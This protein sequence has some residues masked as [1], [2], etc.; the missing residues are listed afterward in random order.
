[1]NL[2]GISDMDILEASTNERTFQRG[3]MYYYN[4]RV[5]GL[6]FNSSTMEY[7]AK[8]LGSEVY[9]VRITADEDGEIDSFY[10][11]CPAFKTYF[12]LCK[13]IVAFLFILRDYY[14]DRHS[15]ISNNNKSIEVIFEYISQ[16]HQS[17]D[18]REVFLEPVLIVEPVK[19]RLMSRIE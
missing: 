6:D 14:R 18:K 12:G 1:M 17:R 16:M 2:Y 15:V 4:K 10:C 8:V 11:S 5:T 9:D 3:R 7:S 19:G 13:H